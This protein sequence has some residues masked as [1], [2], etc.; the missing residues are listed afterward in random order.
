MIV[1]KM[2]WLLVMHCLIVHTLHIKLN[3][4]Y[5]VLSL[6]NSKVIWY[7]TFRQ[8]VLSMYTFFVYSFCCNMISNKWYTIFIYWLITRF[9]TGVPRRVPHVEQELL[10]HPE[11]L[12]SLVFS[13]LLVARFLVFCVVFCLSFCPFLFG[14]CDVWPSS[15]TLPITPLISSN[16]SNI[17]M[18]WCHLIVDE[19]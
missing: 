3:V 10:F 19:R 9:V 8:N 17:D 2:Q 13:G 6:V 18:T 4:I 16:F 1:I 7:I 12:S 11:H 15:I 5:E 14:H